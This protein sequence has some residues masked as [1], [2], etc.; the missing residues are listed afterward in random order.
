MQEFNHEKVVAECDS[1]QEAMRAASAQSEQSIT[2]A[3][4]K[5]QLKFVL[6]LNVITASCRVVLTEAEKYRSAE[7][8][9]YDD[10]LVLRHRRELLAAKTDNEVQHAQERSG[11]V[12]D[13]QARFLEL[14]SFKA[15]NSL[16]G[17]AVEAGNSWLHGGIFFILLL[18]ETLINGWFFAQTNERGMLGGAGQA[19]V[20]S[21]INILMAFLFAFWIRYINHNRLTPQILG[22]FGV[23]CY[24][25]AT[26]LYNCFVGH[27]RNVLEANLEIEIS[28]LLVSDASVLALNNFTDNGLAG[29]LAVGDVQSVTLVLIGI[30]LSI[31]ALY[32][33]YSHGD[34]YPGYAA[35]QKSFAVAVSKL[36]S[37]RNSREQPDLAEVFDESIEKLTVDKVDAQTRITDFRLSLTS[38]RMDI[39]RLDQQIEEA[40]SGLKGEI[41]KFELAYQQYSAQNLPKHIEKGEY[42][43]NLAPSTL[44]PKPDFGPHEKKFREG[45]PLVNKLISAI[46]VEIIDRYEEKEKAL[47]ALGTDWSTSDQKYMNSAVFLREAEASENG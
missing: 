27:Y 42:V 40:K 25:A 13:R 11:L 9:A 18:G 47:K 32:K 36:T 29:A 19:F 33:T 17:D 22:Y 15:K 43:A 28:G 10:E 35:K 2:A 21:F 20:F 26:V 16:V 4:D 24:I 7:L 8:L 5:I 31:F 45:E 46:S 12:R 1:D 44:K 30:I 23:I 41:N 38:S 34:G 39:E 6:E 14:N 37:F 3:L